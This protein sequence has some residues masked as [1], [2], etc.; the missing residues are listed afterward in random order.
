MGSSGMARTL[1]ILIFCAVSLVAEQGHEVTVG[2][3][4]PDQLIP[5]GSREVTILLPEGVGLEKVEVTPAEGVAVHDPI[6]LDE[7]ATPGRGIRWRMSFAVDPD[8]VPGDREVVFLTSAGR[9][10]P[11][12]VTIP[13]H[14]PQILSVDVVEMQ[15]EPLSALLALE[16]YDEEGDLGEQPSVNARLSCGGGTA[17]AMGPAREVEALDNGRYRVLFRVAA[18]SS[19]ADPGACEL[20]V[21]IS[22][23]PGWEGESKLLVQLAPSGA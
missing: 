19:R 5:G 2:L 7:T 8:A 9:S 3:F 4:Y 12:T 11:R 17:G 23:Q 16:V 20:A 18:P 21:K 22:D 15:L 14:V 6:Q 1:G 10:E 13:P